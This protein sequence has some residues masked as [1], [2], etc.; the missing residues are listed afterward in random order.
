MKLSIRWL[1][2]PLAC[3]SIVPIAAVTE[4]VSLTERDAIVATVHGAA[5][6]SL[7]IDGARL[8]LVPEQLHRQADWVFLSARMLDGAGKRFDYGGTDQAEAARQG[9]KSDLCAAL[10]RRDGTQWKLIELAVG[11]TDVA[12]GGWTNAHHVP[13]GL[14]P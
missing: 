7:K 4:G 13:A 5:A 11:P 10:L 6:Q 14:I 2:L 1:A 3:L 9:G 12:W 8:Y